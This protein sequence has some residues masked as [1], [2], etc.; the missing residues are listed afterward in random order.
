MRAGRLLF[1]V[2]LAASLT[3][4]SEDPPPDPFDVRDSVE[5]LH[6]THAPAMTE[7]EVVDGAGA[8][9]AV[10]TTDERGSLMFRHLP[11]GTGY[12]VRTTSAT[13][14]LVTGVHE[15]MTVDNSLP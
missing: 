7:L 8:R 3:A 4:C 2:S 10:G 5:Q 13:P 6:V 1:S 14:A 11:P 15:V 12:K 9:V